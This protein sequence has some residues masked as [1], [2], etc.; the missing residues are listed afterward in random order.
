MSGPSDRSSRR[1]FIQGSVSAA[2]LLA[3]AGCADT[4]KSAAS[5]A[6]ASLSVAKHATTSPAEKLNLAFVGVDGKGGDALHQF[7]STNCNYV[8]LCDIDSNKLGKAAAAHQG[9]R[10]YIDFRKM[11][12]QKDIDAVVISTTDH[13]H[14]VIA[15]AAMQLGK[16][17]YCEKPLT[18]DIYEARLLTEAARK[19]KV[20]TQMGNQGHATDG[21]RR[22][23]EWMQSGQLGTIKSVHVWTDRPIWPQGVKRPTETPKAPD[24]IAWDLWLGPA[25]ERPFHPGY[26]PNDWRG[27]W[28]FG[29]GALGDMACHIMDTAYWALDLRDPISVEAQ[30]EGGTSESPPLWSIIRYEFPATKA[31]PALSMTWYDGKKKPPAELTGGKESPE[32]NGVLIVGEKAT[33]FAPYTQMPSLIDGEKH[34]SF[35]APTTTLA[36]SIGHFQE[37]VLA[38]KGG[39]RAG[40]NFD[41]AGPLTETVLLGNLAVRSGK[42]IEWDARSMT[43]RNVPDANQYVRREYRKGWSLGM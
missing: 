29:T 33:M 21:S 23:V 42:K 24:H 40:S 22:Q 12:E 31:R 36:S 37:F 27:W 26:L 20:A 19:Y 15:M 28:D 39:P 3:S 30:S 10:A 38:A 43:C 41:Y 1:R 2:A 6:P 18:H 17:V 4:N 5:N 8:A 34:T 9:A 11:L 25:P 7:G 35:K 14:A 32:G 13:T 16:H